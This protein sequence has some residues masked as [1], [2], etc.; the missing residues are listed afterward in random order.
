M[1]PKRSDTAKAAT[2]VFYDHLNEID[3]YVEDT[4]IGFEKI[5]LKIFSRVFDGKYKIKKIFPL[6]G[7]SSVIQEFSDNKSMISK[8]T[9][10]IVDGDLDILSGG[11]CKSEPGFYVFPFY[12]IENIIIDNASLIKI[13]DEED[14]LKSEVEV[15]NALDFNR[16]IDGNMLL[17]DLFVEYA[18]CKLLAPTVQTVAYSITKLTLSKM[19]DIDEEKVNERICSIRG[20]IIDAVGNDVY[21]QNKN[22]IYSRLKSNRNEYMQFISG[23]D[24]LFPLIHTRLRTITKTKSSKI[25]IQQRLARICDISHLNK[26]P[27][28]VLEG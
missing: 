2:K 21:L 7:K 22:R 25:N 15:D 3:I 10:Y 16:W 4:T 11:G 24:Y 28:F 12:C 20:A 9:I 17:L 1:L 19:G 13:G 6:G 14:V 8:P 26:V 27:D 5:Y 18:L 23:K